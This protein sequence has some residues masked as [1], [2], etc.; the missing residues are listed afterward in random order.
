[1][2]T[3]WLH[4]DEIKSA[5]QWWVW[6]L[7]EH[8]NV[9]ERALKSFSESLTTGLQTLL[10]HEFKKNKVHRYILRVDYEPCELL[11][12]AALAASIDRDFLPK[13]TIMI[14]T[15]PSTQEPYYRVK[16]SCGYGMPY[17]LL[18]SRKSQ[19][20]NNTGTFRVYVYC[21]YCVNVRWVEL[22]CFPHNIEA[23]YEFLDHESPTSI[24]DAVK[25][26]YAILD[27][28]YT[29]TTYRHTGPQWQFSVFDPHGTVVYCSLSG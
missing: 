18:H 2:A 24:T 7:R 11:A 5:T 20:V 4:A 10:P 1:M 17:L 27:D 22:Q 6:A 25:I 13:K 9:S 23:S 12:R 26:G 14:F 28:D 19:V 21:P 3:K 16:V 29:L 15:L 8:R